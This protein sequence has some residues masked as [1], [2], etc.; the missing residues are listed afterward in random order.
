MDRRAFLLNTAQFGIWLKLAPFT[1]F[2]QTPSMSQ[3]YRK[4]MVID[5]LC[6]VNTD[7]TTVKPEILKQAVQSGVTAIDWT[8][9]A[10]S[11]DDTVE[12]ISFVER[13]VENDPEHWRIVRRQADFDNA[14]R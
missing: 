10:P 13:M 6:S 5:A 1:A 14:K 9:S 12:N 2:A 8:V 11:F 7:D 3:D 4:W